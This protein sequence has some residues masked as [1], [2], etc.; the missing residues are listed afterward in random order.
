ML[1]SKNYVRKK[2]LDKEE[3][4]KAKR[5]KNVITI[6][7]VDKVGKYG[8]CPEIYNLKTSI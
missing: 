3:K 7:K 8:K 4:S 5:K 1:D 2:I 6:Q